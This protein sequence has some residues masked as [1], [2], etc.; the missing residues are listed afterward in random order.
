MPEA[1]LENSL[2]AI[3]IYLADAHY[4]LIRRKRNSSRELCP[5]LA[6]ISGIRRDASACVV[7]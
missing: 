7:A 4:L 3:L 5:L 6:E 2:A 1:D